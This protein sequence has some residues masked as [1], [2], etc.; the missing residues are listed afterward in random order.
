M[1]KKIII[2]VAVCMFVGGMVGVVGA[3]EKKS[4]VLMKTSL[5]NIKIELMQRES[6][7]TVKNFLSYVKAGYYS[8]TILHRVIPGFMVQGGGFTSDMKVKKTGQPIK[9]E[10]SNGLKNDRGTIAMART[11]APDS[12]TSQFFINL[13]NNDNLNRPMPDGHG[14]AVFGRVIEG[15]DVVDKIASVSTGMTMGF[16]NVPKTPVVIKSITVV[17]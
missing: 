17:E 6:P 10:A 12:A 14:Y 9:N 3:A 13:V 4:V 16:P 5:G 15:M 1:F 2:V 11:S 8:G 7:I